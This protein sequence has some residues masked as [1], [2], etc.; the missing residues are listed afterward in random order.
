MLDLGYDSSRILRCIIPTKSLSR[1]RLHDATDFSV[2]DLCAVDSVLRKSLLIIYI[3]SSTAEVI[4]GGFEGGF[5]CI[6]KPGGASSS[7][8][9]FST[10][11]RKKN[12]VMLSKDEVSRLSTFDTR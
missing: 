11:R 2:T 7:W 5:W 3:T 6:P 4:Y 10:D 8:N 1:T 12:V 9:A